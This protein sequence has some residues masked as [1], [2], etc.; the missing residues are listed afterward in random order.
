VS[1]LQP[2]DKMNIFE[3]IKKVLTSEDVA[4]IEATFKR[5]KESKSD[6]NSKIQRNLTIVGA[7]LANLESS[8]NKYQVALAAMTKAF[9]EE[10]I[11]HDKSS[12]HMRRLSFIA[13]AYLC[14][15][16]DVIPDNDP[17]LGYADDIYMFFLV[18]KEI[19]KLDVATYKRIAESYK[20][21]LV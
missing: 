14:D 8:D 15:P 3:D 5:L 9:T 16:F 11:K 12:K 4:N 2:V 10:I 19:K 6:S 18:L 20:K 7:K 1:N 13:I 17:D 21:C